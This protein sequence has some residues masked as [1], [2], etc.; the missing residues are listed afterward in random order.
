VK[1][2]DILAVQFG[3]RTLLYPTFQFSH[4]GEP[5]PHLRE[6]LSILRESMPSPWTQ[7]F[8]L[9]AKV[10]TFNGKTAAEM[11]RANQPTPVLQAAKADG[12]SRKH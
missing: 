6:V 10:S 12:E 7:A 1:R 8:W 4:D 3:T 11:L 2:G 9:N 5:L